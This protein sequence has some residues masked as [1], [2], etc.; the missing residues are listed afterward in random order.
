MKTSANSHWQTRMR[1]FFDEP[2]A[3][4]PKAP[5]I[6]SQQAASQNS[7]DALLMNATVRQDAPAGS[8]K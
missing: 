6:N 2:L 1:P 5:L 7:K 3:L 4:Y 8:H